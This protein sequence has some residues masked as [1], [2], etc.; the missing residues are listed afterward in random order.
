MEGHGAGEGRLET[1]TQH[2]THPLRRYGCA[3]GPSG[4]ALQQGQGQGPNEEDHPY[5]A[6]VAVRLWIVHLRGQAG[7]AGGL[8]SHP[9]GHGQVFLRAPVP[10]RMTLLF[11]IYLL[12]IV[13]INIL[14]Y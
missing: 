7:E 6:R 1:Q 5:G 10:R 11:L 12:F 14:F 3:A 8:P 4:A 9:Q 2:P 13:G